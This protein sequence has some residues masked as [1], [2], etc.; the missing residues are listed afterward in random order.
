[1]KIKSLLIAIALVI[2]STA[3]HAAALALAIGASFTLGVT[4][5]GTQPFTYQWQKNGVDLPGATAA[6][7]TVS[8]V[9]TVDAGSYT[10]RVSNAF[11][12]TTSDACPVAVT[13]TKPA[14]VKLTATFQ[15][16]S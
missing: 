6:T 9:T 12:S 8:S 11:G 7:Y 13:G 5:D 16:P 4:A 15:N 2:G 14:N 1:M 3:A 10:V